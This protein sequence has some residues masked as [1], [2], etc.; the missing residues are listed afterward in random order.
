MQ[1]KWVKLMILATLFLGGGALFPAGQQALAQDATATTG[2]SYAV[3]MGD[4]DVTLSGYKTSNVYLWKHEKEAPDQLI[5]GSVTVSSASLQN[6]GDKARITLVTDSDG[7]NLSNDAQVKQVLGA[8]ADKLT[9]TAYTKGEKNLEGTAEIYEGLTFAS[10]SKKLSALDFDET[11]GKAKLAGEVKTPYS[12]VLGVDDEYEKRGIKQADGTYRFQEDAVIHPGFN[13]TKDDNYLRDFASVMIDKDTTIDMTGHA[14]DVIMHGNIYNGSGFTNRAAALY[15]P[16]SATLTINNPGQIRLDTDSDYYYYA[17]IGV[18]TE[19]SHVVIHNDDDPAHA[20]VMR[21][22]TPLQGYEMNVTALKTFAGTID[23]DGLVDIYTNGGWATNAAGGRISIGGGSIVTQA[24]NSVTAR[25]GGVMNVNVS[26]SVEKGLTPGNHTVNITAKGAT[27]RDKNSY[28]ALASMGAWVGADTNATVNAAL[29]TADSTLYGTIKEAANTKDTDVDGVHLFLQNG[30]QWTNTGSSSM[31]HLYGGKDAAHVGYIDMSKPA[32]SNVNSDLT[33]A[34]YTGNTVIYYSQKRGTIQGGNIHIGHAEMTDGEKA[35]LTI[36]TDSNGINKADLANESYMR[37][38]LNTLANKLY[39]AAYADGED[40]LK[41]TVQIAEGLTSQSV[42]RKEDIHFTKGGSGYVEGFNQKQTDFTTALTGDMAKDIAYVGAN[43][44]KEANK[45][46]FTEDTTITV[47]NQAAIGAMDKRK[48]AVTSKL[49]NLQLS[50]DGDHGKGLAAN[51]ATLTLTNPGNIDIQAKTGIEASYEGNQKGYINL[52]GKT[53]NITIQQAKTGILSSGS[54]ETGKGSTINILNADGAVT[55]NNKNA[56]DTDFVGLKTENNGTITVAGR[57]NIDAGN[58]TAIQGRVTAKGAT[59]K[60]NGSTAIIVADGTDTDHGGRLSISSYNSRSTSHSADISIDAGNGYAIDATRGVWTIGQ[61]SVSANTANGTVHVQ[62]HIKLGKGHGALSLTKEN[63]IW[64]GTAVD[65]TDDG[66]GVLNLAMEPDAVWNHVDKDG[67]TGSEVKVWLNG[68]YYPGSS[69]D[70]ITILQN[71]KKDI[72]FKKISYVDGTLRLVF[73]HEVNSPASIKG[74]NVTIDTVRTRYVGNTGDT[75]KVFAVTDS[76]GINMSDDTIVGNVLK[77]LAKKITYT[78]PAEDKLI[79]KVGIADGLTAKSAMLTE[80]FI[81]FDPVTGIGSYTPQMEDT[82]TRSMT[83]DE[84]YD[85]IYTDQGVRQSQFLYSLGKDTT[86]KADKAMDWKVN[87]NANVVQIVGQGHTLHLDAET[88]GIYIGNE[89]KDTAKRTQLE[90]TEMPDLNITAGTNGSGILVKNS[91]AIIKLAKDG[92]M[93]IA[94]KDGTKGFVGIKVVEDRDVTDT[95]AG[96]TIFSVGGTLDIETPEEIALWLDGGESLKLSGSDNVIR[97]EGGTLLKVTKSQD[98]GEVSI[99]GKELVGDLDLS[100]ATGGTYRVTLNNGATWT[101]GIVNDAAKSGKI[102]LELKNDNYGFTPT[103]WTYQWEQKDKAQDSY[104]HKVDGWHTGIGE[105]A[106]YMKADTDLT[107]GRLKWGIRILYDHDVSHPTQILGGNVT[108]E[109]AE[110]VNPQTTLYV[111]TDSDGINMSDET[112]VSQVLN[113]LA[114][115]IYYLGTP[116]NLDSYAEIAEGLT[117]VS[118]LKTGKISY[119]ETTHQGSFSGAIETPGQVGTLFVTPLYAPKRAGK[120]ENNTAYA[121]AGVQQNGKYFIFHKD[122]KLQIS[123]SGEMPYTSAI[124]ASSDTSGYAAIKMDLTNHQLDVHIDGG[125]EGLNEAV[126]GIKGVGYD[127]SAQNGTLHIMAAN[128][129]GDAIGVQTKGKK[130][131]DS[132]I[133]LKTLTHIDAKTGFDVT[134][135]TVRVNAGTIHANTLGRVGA[136]GILSIGNTG[137]APAV[138]TGN[139]SQSDGQLDMNLDG[140]DSIWTGAMDWTGGSNSLMLTNGATWKN[141]GDSKV[142]QI[143]SGITR[144]V[145]GVIDMTGDSGNIQIDKFSGNASIL[146]K[147]DANDLTNVYGGDVTVTS[148]EAGS[149]ITLITDRDGI[150]DDGLREKETVSSLFQAM[151]N[152]LFYTNYQTEG[153]L[154]GI[155]Q[156]SEGLT[157]RAASKVTGAMEFT[158]ANGQGQYKADS[159]TP[160]IYPK[161]QQ[162][163]TFTTVMTGNESADS[164]YLDG[165]VM[166]VGNP[167]DIR[168]EFTKDKTAVELATASDTA[169]Q[170]KDTDYS[171]DMKGHDLTIKNEGNAG[172]TVDGKALTFRNGSTTELTADKVGIEAKNGGTFSTHEGGVWNISAETAAKADGAGS[173]VSLG[174]GKIQSTTLAEVSNGGTISFFAPNDTAATEYVGDVKVNDADS[175]VTLG[176]AT[177]GST[178]TGGLTNHGGTFEMGLQ[179]GG[180]WNNTGKEE[181]NISLLDAT[182]TGNG[183]I[184]QNKD[185]GGI[186][187]DRFRGHA[188]VLYSH[189][190]ADPTDILGGD[191]TVKKADA[192]SFLTLRT[193]R[194]GINMGDYHGVENV[195]DALAKKLTYTDAVN[196]VTNLNGRVEIAE[197]LTA[198]SAAKQY[199]TIDFNKTTGQGSY[200]K[201]SMTPGEADPDIIWGSSETMMMRGAKNAMNTSMLSWRSNVSDMTTRMGDLHYGADDGIW[202]RTFGGKIKYDKGTSS[203]SNSF[204][205]AQVGADKLFKNGWHFGGAFDYSKGSAKYEMGGEGDPKLYTFSLYGTKLF[206]DGQYVDIAVKAGHTTNSYTVYNDM[207]HKLDGDYS[208]NGFGISAEYG[209]R[210]GGADGFVE[211][212]LQLTLS[213]LG[214]ADYDGISDYT[215]GK[216]MHVSQDG[217]TSFI[218]RLG[219]AAGK[220]TE[221]GNFYL[222]AGLLHEFSGK[223]S[224]TFSAENEP[225]STVD[226]DFGDTWAELTLGGT[227]RLSPSSMLYGDITKSFGG[228]Y[229]VQWKANVGVR[230]TF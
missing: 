180:V 193:D 152:K 29:T 185:S 189:S 26:G 114:Q 223:T 78:N 110:K 165:G 16:G 160:S 122:S 43:V 3:L 202:A 101:G 74:G 106:I 22:T 151:A 208:A 123:Q 31:R 92:R 179:N 49:A 133:D 42:T 67:D 32:D 200:K 55:I 127:V 64:T 157:A 186:T 111:R 65:G 93:H 59:I 131:T 183:V 128:A 124:D 227:Y 214:S 210:F 143:V 161:D 225:T 63:S 66:S 44:L 86:I 24:Y 220:T 98:K 39:Y 58:G 103:L 112:Q 33:I 130:E 45:A 163:E 99:N 187:V 195:L 209:K 226:Q 17:D 207:G 155:L 192:N 73:A 11:T 178:W 50:A 37:N 89:E 166:K 140:E 177:E 62:G 136:N 70:Q 113:A 164:E 134:G 48:L 46:T 9:Y 94:S 170:A 188:L 15:V 69:D 205:G 135:G 190:A 138:W 174:A 107:I 91:S 118:A 68:T 154:T 76:D 60:T 117:S 1:R 126:A 81:R 115:K 109:E 196:G 41:G 222:T 141:T 137:D 217:M 119:D 100:G 116:E 228:D 105:S 125:E 215:G 132:I 221:R 230:F 10:A 97:A 95:K 171:I 144:S 169:I 20:V 83:G 167:S 203:F 206:E 218:G 182:D 173:S 129:K 184:F 80:G 150:S 30:A 79:G 7:L 77:S 12:G 38:M 18:M 153:N 5:G 96:D 51:G 176:I 201:N 72:H 159:A 21:V 34:N 181:A 102:T 75:A 104:I 121:N 6:S 13:I 90:F 61:K 168:Y 85:Q 54:A 198:A 211:P 204:W 213:R 47:N 191:V 229:K 82:F 52:N 36:R 23:I 194:S 162:K 212:Q 27:D 156:I 87:S 108:I 88:A 172:I 199:G 28:A 219:V 57:V 71:S 224:T 147:H 53:S 146:Y 84:A 139:M 149:R 145:G 40:H 175:K 19:D 142:G 56:E 25:S 4:E 120:D 197:G 35:S 148:A 2:R 216:K 14:L 8:L 158:G